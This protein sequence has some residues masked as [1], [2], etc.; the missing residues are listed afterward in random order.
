GPV[1]TAS[2][3][4]FGKRTPVD[5]YPAKSRGCKGVISMKT[6]ERNGDIVGAVQVEEEDDIMLISNN[7][8]LI[9]TPVTGV[10]IISRNTQGVSLIRLRKNEKLVGL[11]RII[12]VGVE[13]E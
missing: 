5:D 12:D 7:G 9:R 8:T 10:S 6:S 11:D 3:N 2:V 4:G 1:L 13:E